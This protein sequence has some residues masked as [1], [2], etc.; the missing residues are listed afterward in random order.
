MNAVEQSVIPG[1]SKDER[2]TDVDTRTCYPHSQ[3]TPR[4][5]FSAVEKNF[6]T[7]AR[8]WPENEAT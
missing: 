3:A 4:F 1:G 2:L 5:Y 8:E 6:S 7:A